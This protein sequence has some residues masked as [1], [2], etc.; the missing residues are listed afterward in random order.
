MIFNQQHCGL[1][2]P[3]SCEDCTLQVCQTK[4]FEVCLLRK[5][6]KQC[7][8]IQRFYKQSTTKKDS[9]F[10]LCY[11]CICSIF[12]QLQFPNVQGWSI[13]QDS[14]NIFTTG[15]MDYYTC[16]GS[17]ISCPQ[18]ELMTTGCSGSRQGGG[19]M[20]GQVRDTLKV[21]HRRVNQHAAGTLSCLSSLPREAL[22]TL[23]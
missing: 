16:P 2:L 17:T 6:K 13:Q 7:P 19:L 8:R 20:G 18:P 12:L 10:N 21:D 14:Q 1:K 11:S 23:R 3:T 5:W 4:T 22:H 15:S 9:K